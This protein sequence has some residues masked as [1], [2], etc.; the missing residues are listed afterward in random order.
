MCFKRPYIWDKLPAFNDRMDQAIGHGC[1]S[2]YGDA[3]YTELETATWRGVICR[4]SLL[5]RALENNLLVVS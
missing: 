3:L 2:N 5:L 1:N 4:S